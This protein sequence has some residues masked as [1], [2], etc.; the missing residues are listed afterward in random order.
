[1]SAKK[2]SYKL[3]WLAND[4]ATESTNLRSF[5]PLPDQ[6]TR[7]RNVAIP[8][9]SSLFFLFFPPSS[10]NL[11]QANVENG[12]TDD[13][14]RISNR[15]RFLGSRSFLEPL[16]TSASMLLPAAV[17]YVNHILCIR[18]SAYEPNSCK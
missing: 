9:D 3:L 13:A 11:T 2:D 14:S 5:S 10:L 4:E 6:G 16:G 18:A 12:P 1:M 17:A 7:A 8:S 15:Q